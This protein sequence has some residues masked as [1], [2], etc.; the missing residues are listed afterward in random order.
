[1]E[2]HSSTVGLT[3]LAYLFSASSSSSLVQC[4]FAYL[5]EKYLLLMKGPLS[6]QIFFSP[7][8]S[9]TKE[10]INKQLASE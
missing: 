3:F 6:S 5:P 4:K 2:G 8:A 7:L 10:R 9:P 1:M